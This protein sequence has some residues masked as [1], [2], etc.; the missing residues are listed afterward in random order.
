MRRHHIY[1]YTNIHIYIYKRLPIY[2]YIYIY[3]SL[4]F[5]LSLSTYIYIYAGG[6][7]TLCHLRD[8]KEMLT[9]K[10]SLSHIN[11]YAIACSTELPAQ[12]TKKSTFINRSRDNTA[13]RAYQT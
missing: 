12:L 5:Y 9:S 11:S 1:I 10:K 13:H 4:S 6:Q 7:K 3:T 8:K 2:V